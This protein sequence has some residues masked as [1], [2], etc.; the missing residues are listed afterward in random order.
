VEAGA[1]PSL[2]P[3]GRPATDPRARDEVAAVWGVAELP[4][5]FGR[6]TGQIVEAAATGELGALLVAGVEAVDL[7]DPARAL[8]AL[9]QVGFL[10]SLELRPSEVTE[11]ADVVFPVAAVAEKAGTFLNWEGRARMFEAALKPEQLTRAPAPTDARVLHML[12][13]ALDVH[14][15]L[16]DVKS[17]R[18]ELDR[19]GGW[20]GTHAS[21][22]HESAQPLPR[23]GDGEAVLAGHRLLL[24]QGRLQEGDAALAGTRHAAVARLSAVTAAETGVKDGDLL[25]VTGPSG[26]VELP[27]QVTDMP[28]RVV[29]VPLNSVGRGVPADTGAH[30]GGLVRIGP[31]APG[32][33]DVTPE[34]RA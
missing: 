21:D 23:A 22:P 16:P 1:I 5:R 9:D 13:D 30:P 18:R 27:L 17:V 24:D 34:V 29:W 8:E 28:D 32:T 25:A 31:A 33:P 6:D 12:A 11:R 14:F 20:T 3:G 10:V 4:A 26:S 2:L 15:A 19:L 7:P